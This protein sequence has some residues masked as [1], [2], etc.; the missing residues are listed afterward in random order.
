MMMDRRR[1]M[2][3]LSAVGAASL[4]PPVSNGETRQPNIV[5]IVADDL[6]YGELGS[7]GQQKIKTPHLDQLAEE[8]MRF[9]QFYSGQAV[10]APSRCVLMTGKHTGHAHIRTNK[11]AQPEGQE[12]I[13]AETWTMAKMLKQ[14]GYATAAIGKWGLGAPG[15]SGDPNLQGFDLFFGYNCQRHAHNYYPRYLYRNAERILLPGND[16][17]LTGAHYA[18]DLMAEEALGFIRQNKDNP[19]FLYYPTPVPH[20]ALQV[21]D[22]SLEEYKGKWDDPPY[23]GKTGGYLPHAHPRAA[24]AGMITRMDRDIGRMMSLLKELNLDDNTLVIFTSDNGPTF[25]DGPDT[26]F[27]SS[28]DGLRGKKGDLYEGGIRVP[29]IARWPGKIQPGK[30]SHHLSAF[31]D[32]LPTV[33]DVTGGDEGVDM[34]GISLLPTLTGVGTQKQHDYLYWE[35]PSYSGQQA[36]R[37]GDWK[38]I[39]RNLSRKNGD[40]SF[41]LYNLKEDRSESVDVA[42]Q[43]PDVMRKIRD[44]SQAAHV[45]SRVFPM[46]VLDQEKQNG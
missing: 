12:P 15:S 17:G 14:R 30:T 7:Y 2:Q 22:D 41:A 5:L 19:F 21:P 3:T 11:E 42:A 35:F 1:F 36:I 46:P 32:F 10:C 45:P 25:L 31:W 13:P 23:D 34:D 33:A 43:N 29:M 28:N 6:G 24:Y 44:I 40:Q 18:P 20:L 8:G 26:D 16:R 4:C 37:M 9:T 39:R 38:A 27:F